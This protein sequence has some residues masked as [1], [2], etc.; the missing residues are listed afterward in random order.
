MT[1]TVFC[2][3]LFAALLHASWNAIVKAS[4]DKL[5]AAIGVSGSAALTALVALPFAPQPSLASVPYLVLSSALQ[6]VYT[7]LV[8]K[9]YQVSD[10]SQTY[11]LMRGTA[12]LLVAVISVAFLGDTLSPL[13]WTGIG[14]ICLAILAMACNGRTRSGYGI[15]L[16]LINACF[17]AGYTLVDGTGVRLSDTALGYTLWSFFMNG[18]CLLSWSMIYRRQEA[19]RYLRQHW[20]KGAIGGLSTMGSYGLALWAMTQAPLAVVAALRETSILFGAVIALVLLKEKLIALRIVAACGIAAGAI[21]LRL[22]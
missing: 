21:L 14:V 4:G 5:Y 16:A 7:V 22:S 9:T 8:A 15:T 3:L 13:A 6:V 1:I 17:I 18:C 10:M 2:V 11:P 20:K 12:P 19:S